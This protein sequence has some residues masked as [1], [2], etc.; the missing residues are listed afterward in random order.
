[1]PANLHADIHDEEFLLDF[2][3]TCGCP[4]VTNSH[5]EQTLSDAHMEDRPWLPPQ[6]NRRSKEDIQKRQPIFP[7]TLHVLT[8]RGRYL[9]VAAKRNAPESTSS[10]FIMSVV[11]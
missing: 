1:M 10:M 3:M 4:K 11:K 8:A 9:R 6:S 2:E 7:D 5:N